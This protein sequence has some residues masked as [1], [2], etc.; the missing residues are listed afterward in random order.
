M[1]VVLASYKTKEQRAQ[2]V[3]IGIP[4]VAS[5]FP[6]LEACVVPSHVT[7][8]LATPHRS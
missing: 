7:P 1:A 2:D 4:F 3:S 6:E 5:F 8:C